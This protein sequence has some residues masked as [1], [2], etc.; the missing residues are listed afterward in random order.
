MQSKAEAW[1]QLKKW[2]HKDGERVEDKEDEEDE[3]EDKDDEDEE[4]EG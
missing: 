4:K 3:D 1:R 2:D